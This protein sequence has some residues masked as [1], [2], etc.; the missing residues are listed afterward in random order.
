MTKFVSPLCAMLAYCHPFQR[1]V[2][3]CGFLFSFVFSSK[4]ERFEWEEANKP[5]FKP[6]CILNHSHQEKKYLPK[7]KSITLLIYITRTWFHWLHNHPPHSC[8]LPPLA[9]SLP[10]RGVNLPHKTTRNI[11]TYPLGHPFQ[12]FNNLL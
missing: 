3:F 11:F 9:F 6:N 12:F 1:F 4:M 5:F 2:W 8:R 7:H 10:D